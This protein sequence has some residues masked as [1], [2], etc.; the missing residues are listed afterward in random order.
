MAAVSAR[1]AGRALSPVPPDAP[2]GRDS[3]VPGPFALRVATGFVGIP[4][5]LYAAYLGGVQWLA[6]VSIVVGLGLFEFYRMMRAKGLRPYRFIGVSCGII[7]VWSRSALS[8]ID[9]NLLFAVV[10][11]AVMCIELFR[12]ET[13]YAVYH[14]ATTLLGLVYVGWL[15]AHL[16]QL[17]ELGPILGAPRP[18]AE[19]FD[20]VVFALVVTWGTD[21]AAYLV[22]SRWGRHKLAPRISPRKSIEGAVAGLVGGTLCGL[23]VT[24]LPHH[25]LTVVQAAWVGAVASIA[26]QFGDLVESLIKRDTHIKDSSRTLPGHGGML[27]RLDSV[28]FAVPVVYYALRFVVLG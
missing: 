7:L 21:T 27:D 14:I 2:R 8:T 12:R 18:Y 17:R 13:Q 26:G 1:A 23:I 4:I 19:G 16:V 11:L 3:V 9:A 24:I 28:L 15:G 22:G 10:L 6:L 5:V 25:A 20:Y